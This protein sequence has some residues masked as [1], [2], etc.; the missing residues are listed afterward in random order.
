[1]REDEWVNLL[2]DA[3]FKQIK[4]ES[5]VL[6]ELHTEKRLCRELKGDRQKLDEWHN[7]I[8]E[9]VGGVPGHVR[10]KLGY[11]DYGGDITF[12]PPKA[13]YSAIK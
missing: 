4:K 3:G 6:Y 13:I 12:I 7:Y 1:L 10:D 8:R 5:D 11:F 9:L 2:G